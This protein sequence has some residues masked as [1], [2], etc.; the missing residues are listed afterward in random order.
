MNNKKDITPV[1]K[2]G[3]KHFSITIPSIEVKAKKGS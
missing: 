3:D 1:P 2:P